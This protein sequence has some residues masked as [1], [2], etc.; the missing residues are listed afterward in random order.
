[1]LG[2]I[3][4]AAS[5]AGQNLAPRLGAGSTTRPV[6]SSVAASVVTEML[7]SGLSRLRVLVL[8]RGR[9]GWYDANGGWRSNGGGTGGGL[10]RHQAQI[11]G[12]KIDVSVDSVTETATIQGQQFDLRRANVFLFDG[13]GP[14]S[15]SLVGTLRVE[16]HLIQVNGPRGLESL[17]PVFAIAEIKEFLR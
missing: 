12:L 13:V 3:V 6:S 5:I 11:G 15:G 8:W 2:V 10:T 1:M 14:Q 4:C 16:A 7:A 9:S 17:A